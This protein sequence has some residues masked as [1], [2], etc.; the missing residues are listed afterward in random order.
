[1]MIEFY[2]LLHLLGIMMLF[3]GLG[4]LL[5]ANASTSSVKTKIKILGSISHGVGLML[6]I[7]SGFGLT[8]RLSLS[9]LPTWIYA[10]LL[11]WLMLGGAIVLAKRKASMTFTLALLFCGLGLSAAYLALI[12]PF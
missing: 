4:G 5:M 1:M 7:V 12:K 10:K 3:L 2:K 9:P 6:I 8:A 11:V